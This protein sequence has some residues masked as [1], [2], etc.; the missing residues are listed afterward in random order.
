MH[1]VTIYMVEGVYEQEGS[2]TSVG[3]TRGK[4]Q[5]WCM[6]KRAVGFGDQIQYGRIVCMA[7][8]DGIRFRPRLVMRWKTRVWKYMG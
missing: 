6:G 8:M 4:M 7:N 5:E 3:E 2:I 1:V